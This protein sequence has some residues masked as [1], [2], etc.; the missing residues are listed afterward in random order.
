[1]DSNSHRYVPP[2]TLTNPRVK[3]AYDAISLF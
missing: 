1:M 2:R 3:H